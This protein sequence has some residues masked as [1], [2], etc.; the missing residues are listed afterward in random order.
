MSRS[1][2]V[3]AACFL[4]L[5]SY[6]PAL[7][8]VSPTRDAVLRQQMSVL[9]KLSSSDA[10]TGEN[11]VSRRSVVTAALLIL[12]CTTVFTAV[13]PFAQSASTA[14]SQA[15]SQDPLASFGEELQ[16]T[17][18]QPKWPQE[19]AHP[20]PSVSGTTP[21]PATT[22]AAAPAANDIEAALQKAKAKKQVDP[23]THG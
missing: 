21:P 11:L 4:T 14:E 12:T 13:P 16:T 9:I 17:E 1:L 10:D 23:R 8:W 3:L 19:A 18:F 5:V 2:V 20:L 7:G 6:S 15:S 22:K